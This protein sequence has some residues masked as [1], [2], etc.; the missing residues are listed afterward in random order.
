MTQAG[1]YIVVIGYE[2]DNYTTGELIVN[3]P[4]GRWNGS[5]DSYSTSVS[6]AGLRYSFAAITISRSDDGVFVL[7]P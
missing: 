6:G 2:G 7:I 4:F 3:D 1:H 5:R